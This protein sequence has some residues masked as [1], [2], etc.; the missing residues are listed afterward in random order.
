MSTIIPYA[1]IDGVEYN[2]GVKKITIAEQKHLIDLTEWDFEFDNKQ[3][4]SNY[5]TFEGRDGKIMQWRK[6]HFER[7]RIYGYCKMP[8]CKKD[9]VK[10][11]Q[12]GIYVGYHCI[13]CLTREIVRGRE[14][15]KGC[16]IMINFTGQD[17]SIEQEKSQSYDELPVK[18]MEHNGRPMAM[19]TGQLYDYQQFRH[20]DDLPILDVTTCY[21][22]NQGKSYL[23]GLFK[24]YIMGREVC[25]NVILGKQCMSLTHE[26]DIAS[27]YSKTVPPGVPGWREGHRVD[28]CGKILVHEKCPA[29]A[30]HNPRSL[31]KEKATNTLIEQIK[32]RNADIEYWREKL[33]KS[34]V[35]NAQLRA[36]IAQLHAQLHAQT[37]ETN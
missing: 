33:A 17:D 7:K 24:G 35:E 3:Q 18:F 32:Q 30:V 29:C 37:D 8:E 31:R 15:A 36:E 5:K 20:T 19:I 4:E 11:V 14:L 6:E 9:G 1:K 23:Y 10:C 22:T 25:I 26:S 12:C 16:N 13:N 28:E 2:F 34:E 21:Y 27:F